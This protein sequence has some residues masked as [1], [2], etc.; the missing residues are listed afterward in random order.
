MRTHSFLAGRMNVEWSP[1][2]SQ[3]RGFLSWQNYKLF[4]AIYPQQLTNVVA[5][6]RNVNLLA[7]F[8]C[9]PELINDG[10]SS[11]GGRVSSE[12]RDDFLKKYE[13]LYKNFCR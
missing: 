10:C 8:F 2:S 5:C 1:N 4:A 12:C 13:T 3:Q 9:D 6:A 7:A 11:C